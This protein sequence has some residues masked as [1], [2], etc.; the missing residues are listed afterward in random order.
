MNVSRDSII[1]PSSNLTPKQQVAAM[2]EAKK[3]EKTE[4][5]TFKPA[6][7]SNS[8]KYSTEESVSSNRFE[9]LYVDAKSR[10]DK[11]EVATIRTSRELS[12]KPKITPRAQS[13]E[14]SDNAR[15]S[16]TGAGR[17]STDKISNVMKPSFTPEITRRASS[18]DRS[19]S[20]Q[21]VGERMHSVAQTFAT[22]HAK[23]KE[24]LAAKEATL[25][26]FNPKLNISNPANKRSASTDRRSGSATRLSVTPAEVSQRQKVYEMERAKKREEL[27]KSKEERETKELKFKPKIIKSA[28]APAPI[29]G[30]T[31]FE[32]LQK[33]AVRDNSELLEQL[34]SELTFRPKI[35][36]Y[37]GL[38]PGSGQIEGD[39]ETDEDKAARNV[40]SK[41]YEEAQ[42]RQRQRQD[43][44]ERAQQAAF[45]ELTF[46][47]SIPSA[48]SS[49]LTAANMQAHTEKNDLSSP[50]AHEGSQTGTNRTAS[51]V[52]DRL[53]TGHKSKTA[54]MLLQIKTSIEL[55]ECTFKP[56]V[57]HGLASSSVNSETQES[58]F[59]RLQKDAAGHQK[60][61][62]RLDEEKRANELKQVTNGPHIP[63]S[64]REIAKQRKSLVTA[65]SSSSPKP[66][67]PKQRALPKPHD[68]R[69]PSP[70]YP[71]RHP[72]YSF[73]VRESFFSP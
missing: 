37:R 59:A 39:S 56:T 52:F 11:A 38:D 57:P 21:S 49:L 20:Q 22:R 58:I 6:L 41:L 40:H 7:V 71:V 18:I 34:D 63:E 51:T 64:S 55:Q 46:R 27:L 47:P 9:R 1:D 2:R 48:A 14:R 30:S 72:D 4:G 70:Q 35:A 31:V 61:L 32:R 73:Q 15:Y 60:K 62:D 42:L 33:T 23:R 36:H 54:D 43:E 66:V 16:E 50:T 24:D 28:L 25:N 5:L 69:S 8:A 65:P 10:Q 68:K 44:I 53:S 29:D 17:I 3:R 19:H 13:R 45:A 26:T 12:F 67:S